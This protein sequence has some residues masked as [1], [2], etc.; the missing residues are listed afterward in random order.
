M[1]D[2]RFERISFGINEKKVLTPTIKMV[3]MALMNVGFKQGAW[4]LKN[5]QRTRKKSAERFRAIRFDGTG[6]RIRCKPGG[7]D[8]C[9]E[10][11][12][13]PPAGTDQDLLFADLCGLHPKDLRVV[14]SS[15]FI[16]SEGATLGG[17]VMRM[18]NPEPKMPLAPLAPA[19]ETKEPQEVPP[20]HA[21]TPIEA[22][23]EREVSDEVEARASL[24]GVSAAFRKEI[25]RIDSLDISNMGGVSMSDDFVMDRALVAFRIGSSGEEFV[26]RSISSDAMVRLLNVEGLIKN[27]D[28]YESTR[29]TMKA[30]MMAMVKK[31]YVDRMVYGENTTSGYKITKRGC[32][33]LAVLEQ[34]LSPKLSAMLVKAPEQP[35]TP[36]PSAQP[37]PSVGGEVIG[38]LKGLIDEYESMGVK[39]GELE[40]L[41]NELAKEDED[42]KLMVSGIEKTIGEKTK[43]RDSING[44]IARLE[45]RLV[46]ISAAGAKVESDRSQ[47]QDEMDRFK[48]RRLVIEEQI[49]SKT[50]MVRR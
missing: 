1:L 21:E 4:L 50:G 41:V 22:D 7:N 29:G 42:A 2:V 47:L 28:I 26:K 3:E 32:K 34:M 20:R 43:E 5:P 40:V 31:G 37:S 23:M 33:R 36:P 12:L 48:E 13:F 30:I 18:A 44:E 15:A 46:E 9:Y 49:C 14:K 16:H 6:V 10:W 38:T 19:A 39:I 35:Q 8:T 11:T 25:H 45:S 24:A 17:L 27:S